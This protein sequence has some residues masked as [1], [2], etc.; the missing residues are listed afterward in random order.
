MNNYIIYY[1]ES[2]KLPI[3]VFIFFQDQIKTA[4]KLEKESALKYPNLTICFAKYFDTKL[5]EGKVC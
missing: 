1:N 5:M 3:L 4:I 2:L